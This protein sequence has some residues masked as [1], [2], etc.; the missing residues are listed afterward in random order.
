MIVSACG[1]GVRCSGGQVSVLVRSSRCHRSHLRPI[2]RDLI[3]DYAN[4]IGAGTPGNQQRSG[5]NAR[6]QHVCGHAR[7][8]RVRQGKGIN[9]QRSR[10]W[11][12]IAGLIISAYGVGVGRIG[13]QVGVRVRSPRCH[14][15]N[16]GPITKDPITDYAYVIAA[17]TPG[18]RYRS[19]CNAGSLQICGHGR[20]NYV[21]QG[22]GNGINWSRWC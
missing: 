4:V 12:V 17:W 3:S 7:R 18:K 14:R 13:S 5:C 11:G 21:R 15:S 9:I 10:L 2:T 16:L 22:K 8:R 20:E 19:G 6:S 1:V